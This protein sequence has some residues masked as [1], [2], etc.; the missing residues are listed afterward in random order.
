MSMLNILTYPDNFLRQPAKP[1]ENIDGTTQKIIEDMSFTMYNSKGVGL[2]AIQVGLD[3]SLIVYDV[4]PSEE[5]RFL[6]VLI[7]PRIIESNGR[8]ISEKEG[9]LSVPDLRA[10][11]KRAESVL[12]EGFDRD[13]NPRR[14]DAEG[15]LAIVLQHEIDHLNGILFI[16]HISALK[17]ELYKRHIKKQLR[18]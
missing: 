18:K 16:D 10:D 15:H 7:N 11:V 1:V 14:I 17:R 4:S 12:V 9:C 6:Q 3:N 8:I 2:A 5:K 13:G